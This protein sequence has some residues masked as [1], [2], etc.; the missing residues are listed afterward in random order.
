MDVH[1]TPVTYGFRSDTVFMGKGAR[2]AVAIGSRSERPGGS[3]SDVGGPCVRKLDCD[4]CNPCTVDLCAFGE[5]VAGPRPG[6]ACRIDDHCGLG[7]TCAL[8]GPGVKLCVVVDDAVGSPGE[9]DNDILCDGLETCQGEP[10]SLACVFGDPGA[11]CAQGEYCDPFGGTGQ[12]VGSCQEFCT[13]AA[14]CDNG[15]LCDGLETCNTATG[16]CVYSYLCRGGASDGDSCTGLAPLEADPQD[17][18][19]EGVCTRFVCGP[20]AICI[21]PGSLS[22]PVGADPCCGFGRCCDLTNDGDCQRRQLDACGGGKV[23]LGTGD[24]QSSV[25]DEGSCDSIAGQ[26]VDNCVFAGLNQELALSGIGSAPGLDSRCPLYSA[27]IAPAGIYLGD[28]PDIQPAA[29]A[30]LICPGWR[31]RT[32]S[33]VSES[34]AGAM[35]RGVGEKADD[36]AW[37]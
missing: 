10:G 36:D 29:C 14:D 35:S 11:V 25:A 1:F 5:C 26:E 28:S 20:G 3:V 24:C 30:P 15:N 33:C 4:D 17:Q 23:F 34:I 32:D 7:G 31:K 13:E 22:C 27:G 9:C 16:Q 12:T 2:G 8:F 21:E 19:P 6:D 18:C 37:P